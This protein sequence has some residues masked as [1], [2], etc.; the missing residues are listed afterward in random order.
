MFLIR[1]ALGV[2]IP[3]GAFRYF[4]ARNAAPDGWTPA[5]LWTSD[6][7]LSFIEPLRR[8]L[9]VLVGFSGPVESPGAGNIYRVRLPGSK[10][11]NAARFIT[12]PWSPP[13]QLYGAEQ[14]DPY[15]FG[16]SNKDE[17]AYRLRFQFRG[18]KGAAT[19]STADFRAMVEV[20]DASGTVMRTFLITDV[21]SGD[22]DGTWRSKTSAAERLTAAFSSPPAKMRVRIEAKANAAGTPIDAM[23][24]GFTIETVGPMDATVDSATTLA[25]AVGETYYEISREPNINGLKLA[26][27]R[28]F[29][30]RRRLPSGPMRSFDASGG[31]IRRSFEIPFGMLTRADFERLYLLWLY[32][33]GFQWGSGY[34]S[35]QGLPQPCVL[36][37]DY[38]DMALS[39]YVDWMDDQFPIDDRSTVGWYPSDAASVRYRGV[40][41]LEER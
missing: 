16:G 38:P 27:P 24:A 28:S 15:A 13:G 37:C 35:N 9:P 30:Q 21:A 17:W 7:V 6:A 22:W 40:V 2:E 39:Y 32:N 36:I 33:H 10:S 14:G 23:F 11:S 12:S 1:M 18:V 31:D 20:G 4:S 41:K 25:P 34:A 3:N 29:R 5:T 19:P 8:G 26:V